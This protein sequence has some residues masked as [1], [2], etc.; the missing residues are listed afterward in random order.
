MAVDVGSA[1]AYLDL[2]TSKFKK[3]LSSALDGLKVFADSSL[4]AST[5]LDG[6]SNSMANAG[7]TMSKWVTV[8][9]LGAG[10]AVTKIT[11]DFETSMSKVQAISGATGN[12]MVALR[13]KAIEM[14]A[15]TKFSAKESADAFTYMAMAGWDASDMIDGISGIMS[16]A[17]A[18]GLDLATTSDIV[19]DALTAFG[20]QASDSAHFADV[21]AQASSSANT[22]VSMLG[23]SFKYVAPVAGSL[24]MSA[25]DVA[26]ALGLMANSGI[27][28]SQ[29]GTTLRTTLTN[30]VKP[31]DDMA[32]L[33]DRLGISA[34]DADGNMQSLRTIMGT[35]RE[36]FSGLTADEQASA[37]ATLAGKEAMSGLLAIVNA[38]QSDFDNLANAI[39]NSNGRA[40]SMAETMMDNLGGSVTLLKSALEGLAIKI[41]STLTPTLQKLTDFVTKVTEKLNEMSDE[42]VQQV[43]KIAAMIAA[44]GPLLL[45]FAK[46]I[47]AV[48]TILKA[49]NLFRSGIVAVATSI[50]ETMALASHGFLELGVR[51][52]GLTGT[53]SNLALGFS[54]TLVPI[55]AVVAAVGVLVA[56]F[57]TLWKNNE[58]FRNNITATWNS[59][60][61]SFSTFVDGIKERIDALNIDFGAIKDTLVSVWQGIT[62]VLAPIFTGLFSMFGTLVDGFLNNI[63]YVFDLVTSLLSGNM[64]GVKDAIVNIITNL[65]STI[66]KLLSEKLSMFL[67]VGKKIIELLGLEEVVEVV[68]Q[69]FEDV[70]QFVLS[71][72][73]A[74]EGFA[75]SVSSFFTET[76][77]NAVEQ[78]VDKIK[79]FVDNIVKFFTVEIP[80]AFNTFIDETIPSVINAVVEWF[81]QLPYKIGFVI[82][83]MLGYL[84]LFGT[85]AIAWAETTISNL[86]DNVVNFFAELSG[87]IHTF[88][89]E[90]YDNIKT[91]GA[92]MT[93]K[94]AETGRNFLDAIVNFFTK[95]S[96]R[97]QDFV[98]NTYNNITDWASN[99]WQ[100]ATET[101][102]NFVQSILNF[103]VMLPSRVYD[104]VTNT[105]NNVVT[106]ASNMV[107]KAGEMASGFV[108]SV[109]NFVSELPGKVKEYMDNVVSKVVGVGASLKQAGKDAFNALW[110]GIK[111]VGDQLTSW[112][113]NFVDGIKNL[114]QGIIDGFN[115]VISK[116]EE[117][118]KA[119]SKVRGSHANGL[120]YV[121]YNGYVAELHQGERVLT[122]AENKEYNKGSTGQGGDVFN[123]YNTKPTPYEY[124]KEMKRAK[125]ELNLGL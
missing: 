115:K 94:A 122:K 42:E 92:D 88:L 101:G 111:E 99:M 76:I 120:D 108:N 68:K 16:L 2:D 1:I 17:A 53:M 30:M 45:V 93:T 112:V 11:S 9:I 71:I 114:V 98:T 121:P 80:E 52:G 4:S 36:K 34:T 107:K 73:D 91:W 117:A 21:L 58:E 37:A 23:E 109:T 43:V 70:K 48:S 78:V 22:N 5:R 100:K 105:Y 118:S 65:T 103:F 123:F 106:W 74:I 119:S 19:T 75:N 10:A 86:I 29:A 55:L 54:G 57:V 51:A 25:E 124:A 33:M 28:A 27:K 67:N 39:D 12:E 50:K 26:I 14:G 56:A 13:D 63:L 97:V 18:D 113:S 89:T 82:G 83:E 66:G 59:I 8:P 72:P 44:I 79:E 41:G 104:Y 47:S 7:G 90:T 38:S 35:L 49:F 31:T 125:R 110:D 20:L 3:G 81:Q 32:A 24:G 46:V 62:E 40:D 102:Q 69:A 95:L 84:Y 60:K 6:L 77:P 15:K 64:D 87:R 116:S 96:G 85:N 61:A